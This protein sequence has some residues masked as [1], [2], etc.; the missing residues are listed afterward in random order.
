MISNNDT[1]QVLFKKPSHSDCS[2]NT[3]KLVLGWIIDTAMVE[4]IVMATIAKMTAVTAGAL[5]IVVW[6]RAV[7]WERIVI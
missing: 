5:E 6:E 2:W 3:V 4:T 7:A 1:K